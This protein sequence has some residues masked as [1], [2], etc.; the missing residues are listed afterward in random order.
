MTVIHEL[1]NPEEARTFLLQGLWLQRVLAVTPPSVKPALEW[2]L[3]V[4]SGGH[5]LPPIGFVADLGHVA[6][7]G[8]WESKARRE[9]RVVHGLPPGLARTY[10]DHVLGKVYGDWTFARA[11]DALRRYHGRDRARGLAFVVNQFRDRA[12]FGGV[13]LSPT[14]IKTLLD[15]SAEE[16]IRLGAESLSRD[17]LDPV[18]ADL[19]EALIAG[20]RRIPEVLGP[21]DVFELE[22]GTALDDLSQRLALRQVL[23]VSRRMEEALPR[24]RLRPLAGRQEVPTRVLDEDTYPVGGFSS[25][26]TRGSVESLL[27]S[28]LAF[29]ERNARPDL[30]DI[31]FLRDELLYY[32]RDE[33]Q[34]LRRRRTFAIVLYPD[35]V[36]TRIKDAVLP[37]QR[38]ILLW[39][40]LQA[41]IDKLSEWLSTDALCFI[42]YFVTQ[43][44][45]S[46][47]GQEREMFET[48]LREQ[49]ENRTAEIVPAIPSQKVEKDLSFRARRSLSHCL[50]VSTGEQTMQPQ[51]TVVTRLQIA[52]PRPAVGDGDGRLVV[53]DVEEPLESWHAA[54]RE[55]LQRWI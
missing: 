50:L 2:A 48:L 33:N 17:G 14:V 54:L 16:A 3:E 47:L 45:E 29:M 27:H 55:L 37:Y 51:D 52:G 11:S 28:Q 26:S 7:G 25:L 4:A 8:D 9:D 23:Q 53:P 24:H 15:G 43:G 46:P 30:F 10:E 6:F 5:P 31:K 44:K 19:Y 35:L 1:R 36:H 39:S 40:M 32:A 42:L 20:A 34:F 38:G 12:G 41:T 18:L 49:L 13:E 22:H 21:E